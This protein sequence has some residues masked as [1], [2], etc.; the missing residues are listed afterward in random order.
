M[1]EEIGG[2]R[3]GSGGK[4]M[5]VYLNDFKKSTHDL[6]C[7]WI[8]SMAAGPCYPAFV[9]EFT[10][11][12]GAEIS[13]DQ[14]IRTLSAMRGPMFSSFNFEVRFF[15]W[16]NRLYNRLMHN[17]PYEQGFKLDEVYL[18]QVRVTGPNVPYNVRQPNQA[19]I[20]S[21]SLLRYLGIKGLG[22]AYGASINTPVVRDFNANAMCAYYDIMYNY[23]CNKQEKDAYVIGVGSSRPQ[24]TI[25]GAATLKSASSQ[26]PWGSS[27][28]RPIILQSYQI[29]ADGD[30]IEF[31]G[32][33]LDGAEDIVYL[34][35]PDGDF[36]APITSFSATGKWEIRDA[37][38]GGKVARIPRGN[39]IYPEGITTL[40]IR[41]TVDAIAVSPADEFQLIPFPLKNISDFR[42]KILGADPTVPFVIDE[43]EMLPYSAAL[44]PKPGGDFPNETAAKLPMSGLMVKTYKSDR[45]NNWIRGDFITGPNGIGEL[46][47]IDTSTDSFTIDALIVSKK[48][49]DMSQRV[50]FGGGTLNDTARVL[51]G[52]N[53]QQYNETPVYL[54]GMSA[55]VV[56]NEVIS[57]AGSE[58]LEGNYQPLGTQGG[59]GRSAH[60]KGGHIRFRQNEYAGGV[61]AIASITPRLCY[62]QGNKWFTRHK[63]LKDYHAPSL[64][65][66]AYQ[67]LLTE[68][69]AAWDTHV[70]M[71]GED[72]SLGE[73]QIP[74]VPAFNS[75]GKQPAWIEYQTNVDEAHGRFANDNDLH[76]M[77][78]GRRYEPDELTGR[79]KDLTTYIDPSKFNYAFAY[80]ALDAENFS[81]QIN[82]DIKARQ[83]MGAIQIPNLM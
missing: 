17:N 75:A 44:K 42:D 12:S 38:E 70:N 66:I 36:R 14:M 7:G 64:D 11:N 6:S 16:D 13:T 22:R 51:Y 10:R 52:G 21:S 57:Q 54:G 3:I 39:L 18:P 23:Y 60:K 80:T 5:D 33:N 72:P 34:D 41:T 20:S 27:Q 1:K 43:N 48:I 32:T 26:S 61:I 79:I 82:F 55:E 46:T 40:A 19:Q 81:V 68:E 69:M 28:G 71:F 73:L 63:T 15:Q 4:G 83:N 47:K 76:F 77:I 8:N 74:G 58:D 37:A 65:G 2:K 31:Y 25:T 30:G 49:Y 78:T 24:P 9:W 50:A 29:P 53:R 56:F 62:T 59:V 67:D 45:F 35:G